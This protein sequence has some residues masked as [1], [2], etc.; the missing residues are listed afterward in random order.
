MHLHALIHTLETVYA[1][2]V[3]LICAT[4]NQFWQTT[5]SSVSSS[6]ASSFPSCLFSLN[7]LDMPQTNTQVFWSYVP[8][9]NH[10]H[11]QLHCDVISWCWSGLWQQ[12]FGSAVQL[13]YVYLHWQ[14]K[15]YNNLTHYKHCKNIWQIKSKVFRN[16]SILKSFGN[17][18][19]RNFSDKCFPT[20]FMKSHC[21]FQ[22]DS[23]RKPETSPS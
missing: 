10:E 13:M 1:S 6:V 22:L 15:D 21:G 23:L 2:K 18:K 8:Q 4:A 14:R 16:F 7:I 11:V 20:A 17:H 19:Q 3:F 12:Q 5:A 9:K